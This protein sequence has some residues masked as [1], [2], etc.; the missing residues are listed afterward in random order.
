MGNVLSQSEIDEL[1]AALASGEADDTP[2]EEEQAEQE[3]KE[4]NFRT[5][6]KFP[7]EQIRSLNI[8]FDNFSRLM[9]THLSTS[10]R[11]MCEVE[12][13]SIEE[14]SYSEFNNSLPSPVI[15]CVFAMEPLEGLLML[16]MNPGIAY[17]IINRLFGG[18][19]ELGE[20]GEASKSFTEI[21][22]TV[23]E[24]MCRQYLGLMVEAWDKIVHVKPQL[25]RIET[26]G[27][28]AQIVTMNE[29]IAIITLS[30]TIGDVSDFINICIPHVAIEPVAQ[31]LSSKLFYSGSNKKVHSQPEKIKEK[32]VNMPVRLRV[33]F[34]DTT[35]TVRD[36]MSLQ[37][38]DVIQLDHNVNKYINVMVEHI[39]KFKGIVGTSGNKYAVRIADVIEED[40]AHE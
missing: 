24:K 37:V 22:L 13:V 32:L 19:D 3:V 35:A 8:V 38:G 34:D 31:Q 29:T 23:L 6:N 11:A 20:P 30:V 33:F 27:Q 17:A 12:V 14:L 36:I 1:L 7:K 9:G 10:L 39:P 40:K 5:A 18:T 25:E 26:S 16:E 15:L 2:Q 21:E 4:Y 28:F